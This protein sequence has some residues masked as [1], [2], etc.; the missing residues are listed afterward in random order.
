MSLL[1]N[2]L[3]WLFGRRLAPAERQRTRAA[4]TC[5]W[6]LAELEQDWFCWHAPEHRAW[7]ISHVRYVEREAF[8]WAPRH[9]GALGRLMREEVVVEG[10]ILRIIEA[11]RVLLGPKT[12]P[13]R[14]KA[15][16]M[17]K[18]RKFLQR[19]KLVAWRAKWRRFAERPLHRAARDPPPKAG[20]RR[21]CK[22]PAEAG[23]KSAVTPAKSLAARAPALARI[24][25]TLS[26]QVYGLE[27][28]AL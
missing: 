21:R 4:D 8:C 17:R 6:L 1:L 16:K 28:A 24:R 7:L 26:P 10:L 20:S 13:V 14:G 19:K 23:A 9:C 22:R 18:G 11:M 15:W 2:L 3:H 5:A 12:E 25:E 27:L